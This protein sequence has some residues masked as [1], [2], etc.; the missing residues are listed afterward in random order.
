VS[1]KRPRKLR[2]PTSIFG[3]LA[4]HTD[5]DKARNSYDPIAVTPQIF[6]GQFQPLPLLSTATAK[7]GTHQ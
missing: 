5:P 4:Y 2:K 7:L 1:N 3:Y 6:G